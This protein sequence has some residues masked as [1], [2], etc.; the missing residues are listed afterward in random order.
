MRDRR[1]FNVLCVIAIAVFSICFALASTASAGNRDLNVK[2]MTRNMDPGVDLIAVAT[3]GDA[4]GLET[5]FERMPERARRIAA[6]I[7]QAKPDLIAIQEASSW[8]IIIKAG[9]TEVEQIVAIDQLDLLMQYLQYYHQ[10][11]KVEIVNPLTDVAVDFPLDD[12]LTE[13]I[14]YT[15][16]DAILVRSDLPPNQLKARWPETHYYQNLMSLPFGDG[17]LTVLRG[18]E[19]VNVEVQ[20]ARFKFVSTHLEAP[21]YDP[22]DETV[23]AYTKG[24]QE[25]Q[26]AE[27]M[28]YLDDARLPIILAGDFNSDAEQTNNYPPDNT[29]SFQIIEGYD[30]NDAWDELKPNN[31]GFTWSLYPVEGIDFEPFERIDLIFS[32]GPRAVSIKR[33][34]ME[35]EDGFFASDHAGVVAVFDLINHHPP[36]GKSPIFRNHPREIPGCHMTL[37]RLRNFFWSGF[38][39]H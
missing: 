28:E 22:S 20:G 16:H 34:G 5:A 26:A 27:L 18:W 31:P 10:H 11:Y 33:T 9:E 36:H 12:Q 39:R 15:D 21:L 8:S 37:D 30:F 3:T 38:R 24:I 23:M 1:A 13:E 29:A 2:V 17:I 7:A 32:N 14:R 35:M 25:A 6:E 19:S 4:S